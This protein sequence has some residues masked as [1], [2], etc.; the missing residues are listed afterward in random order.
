MKQELETLRAEL[1][2]EVDANIDKLIKPIEQG[3]YWYHSTGELCLVFEYGIA[4]KTVKCRHISSDSK[5]FAYHHADTMKYKLNP[6]EVQEALTKQIEKMFPIN[7]KI[8][9]LDGNTIILGGHALLFKNN[10]IYASNSTG[11]NNGKLS[12]MLFKDGLFATPIKTITIDELCQGL[13]NHVSYGEGS[14]KKLYKEY[15]TSNKTQIIET[16]NNL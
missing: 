10:S 14:S 8:K 3:D 12:D 5:E 15:F 7:T 1:H 4:N 6:T 16:L 11:D 2:K 13:Y 9:T